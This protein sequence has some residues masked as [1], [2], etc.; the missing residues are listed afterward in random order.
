MAY[1][2][3]IDE[4]CSITPRGGSYGVIVRDQMVDRCVLAAA[5]I[6]ECIIGEENAHNCGMQY[7]PYDYE[8]GIS[9]IVD[10]PPEGFR[11]NIVLC[12]DTDS[13]GNTMI[14][15]NFHVSCQLTSRS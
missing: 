5:S 12:L 10:N 14:L 15:L 4:D 6:I 11:V 8:R 3:Q 2:V 7:R 13:F 1:G 9:H